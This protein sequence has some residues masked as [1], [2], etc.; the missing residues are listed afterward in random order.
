MSLLLLF[1]GASSGAPVVL[2]AAPYRRTWVLA[3][4]K[5]TWELPQ[6]KT[7]W[8]LPERDTTWFIPEE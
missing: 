7:T 3:E 1:A 5:T 6:R 4:R 8:D 2:T